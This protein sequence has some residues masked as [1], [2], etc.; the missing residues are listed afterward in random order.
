MSS[1]VSPLAVDGELLLSFRG[2]SI[3]I[4]AHGSDVDVELGSLS[5]GV[6][7]LRAW[8]RGA[9]TEATRD[10]RWFYPTRVRIRFRV[11][12]RIV[13]ELGE[14][15]G[16]FSAARLNLIGMARALVTRRR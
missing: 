16:L 10:W 12:G 14:R 1:S 9:L 11:R 13:A 5:T 15:P 6:C 8:R 4:H 2:H 3:P 7:L